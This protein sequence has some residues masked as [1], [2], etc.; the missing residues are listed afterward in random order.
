MEYVKIV[1]TVRPYLGI[2][3]DIIKK[4]LSTLKNLRF[5]FMGFQNSDDENLHNL[6]KIS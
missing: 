5:Y 1:E 4:I 6:L 2:Y 3:F